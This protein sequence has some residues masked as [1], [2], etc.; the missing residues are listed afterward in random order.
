MVCKLL[1][2]ES[3]CQLLDIIHVENYKSKPRSI[4]I[5]FCADFKILLI[6]IV[7]GIFLFFSIILLSLFLS[8]TFSHLFSFLICLRILTFEGIIKCLIDGEDVTERVEYVPNPLEYGYKGQK[9]PEMDATEFENIMKQPL[10]AVPNLN[11][12]Y[13]RTRFKGNKFIDTD[14]DRYVIFDSE[15]NPPCRLCGHM[16]PG[17][18]NGTCYPFCRK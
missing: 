14:Q 3:D 7:D 13:E 5:P 9:L 11:L 2:L 12:E 1:D 6:E 18:K 8:F 15:T 16:V 4:S 17:I 10:A